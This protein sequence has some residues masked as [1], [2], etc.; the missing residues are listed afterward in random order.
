MGLFNCIHLHGYNFKYFVH[1]I[2]TSED[3]LNIKPQP[4]YLQ[5]CFTKTEHY[6]KTGCI[7]GLC[8]INWQLCC[9]LNIMRPK[10]CLLMHLTPVKSHQPSRP[11]CG[12]KCPFMCLH[13]QNIV[14]KSNKYKDYSGTYG[15]QA[16][17]V[18]TSLSANTLALKHY[19]ILTG[20]H[21]N[22]RRYDFR[23]FSQ[24]LQLL[25]NSASKSCIY[26]TCLAFF[27]YEFM[28]CAP[29]STILHILNE[30]TLN[31]D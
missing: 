16:T 22:V 11:Y 30:K 19:S 8:L 13:R 9:N 26:P 25:D 17:S 14:K 21:E 2:Y 15:K 1:H 6:L 28:K 29:I 12:L 7:T 23:Y 5:S 20:D 4:T 3:I 24:M 10:I 27:L 18:S 31:S